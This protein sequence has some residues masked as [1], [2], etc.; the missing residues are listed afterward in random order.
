MPSGCQ[1]AVLA[2]P[3]DVLR[4]RARRWLAFLDNERGEEFQRCVRLVDS[5]VDLARLD[6]KGLPGVVLGGRS[7]LMFEGQRTVQNVA[8]DSTRMSMSGFTC[9]RHE[10]QHHDKRLKVARS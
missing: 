1:T 3:P 7:P 9:S 8:S 6:I 2:L 4:S 10:L 5:E